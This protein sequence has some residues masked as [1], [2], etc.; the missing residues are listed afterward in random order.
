MELDIGKLISFGFSWMK[1]KTCLKY[2]VFLF[3]FYAIIG[4]I[5]NYALSGIYKT[6]AAGSTEILT[7]AIYFAGYTLIIGIITGVVALI[8]F[9]LIVSRGLKLAKSSFA[10]LTFGRFLR[11]I[12]LCIAS[13]FVAGL[14]IF[15]LKWLWI[16]IVGVILFIAGTVIFIAGTG[17]NLLLLGIGG[18]L[19]IASVVL[20]VIYGVIVVYN[21]IRL[22][23]GEIAFVEREQPIMKALKKSWDVTGG[24]VW[25][26]I[27]AMFV[28][29]V[30]IW[31][32]SSV[33]GLPAFVYTFIQGFT[34]AMQSATASQTAAYA[35]MGD[36]IYLAL[37]IPSYLASAI[38]I[39]TSAFYTV[40]IYLSLSKGKK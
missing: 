18:A 27:L 13:A 31:I 30:L 34:T 29:G 21:S 17:G 7:T 24:R 19:E 6:F 10:S 20:L 36:P 9:Y 35:L 5:S 11:L 15:R 38:L 22:A 4:T 26:I 12:V 2:F 8:M 16:L 23:V 28:L 14:S 32:I 1:D 33:L 3:I 39:M 40:G 37:I 25:E